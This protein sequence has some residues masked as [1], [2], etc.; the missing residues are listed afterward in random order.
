MWSL[1]GS[2]PK[3]IRVDSLFG[4]CFLIIGTSHIFLGISIFSESFMCL[5]EQNINS[6]GMY[7]LFLKS[8]ELLWV[9]PIIL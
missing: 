7:F 9:V 1:L 5:E 3:E 2:N 4:L 6:S 8:N